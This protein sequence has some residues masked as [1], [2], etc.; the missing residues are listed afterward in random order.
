MQPSYHK[1]ARG[2]KEWQAEEGEGQQQQQQQQE[3][4]EERGQ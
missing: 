2:S 1:G 4:E 3:E